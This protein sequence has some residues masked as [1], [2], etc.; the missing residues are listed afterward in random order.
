ME[1]IEYTIEHQNNPNKI[2]KF[3]IYK[4]NDRIVKL[5]NTSVSRNINGS[6]KNEFEQFHR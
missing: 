1:N 2:T 3:I 5:V 4:I 6:I